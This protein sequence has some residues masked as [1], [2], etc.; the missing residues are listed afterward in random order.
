MANSGAMAP[1]SSAMSCP[2]IVVPMLAPMMIQTACCR[3]I[4]PELTNPTT[5]TVVADDDWMTA[6]IAAP[7]STPLIR[8]DVSFSRID[9]ILLP[10]AA[11]RPLLIICM[12]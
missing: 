6:V 9:F 12:P 4:R 2:V 11:S 10:A 1:I 5:M 3:V 7:T 8:L